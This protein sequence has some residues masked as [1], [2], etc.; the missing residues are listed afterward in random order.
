MLVGIVEYVFHP[1]MKGHEIW[2][3]RYIN[4][5]DM[6]YC[7]VLHILICLNYYMHEWSNHAIKEKHI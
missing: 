6:E 7:H 2:C 1:I 4:V 3:R 5:T